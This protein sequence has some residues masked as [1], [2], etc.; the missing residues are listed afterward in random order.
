MFYR[1]G[2]FSPFNRIG[3]TGNVSP[4]TKMNYGMFNPSPTLSREWELTCT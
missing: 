1:N 3:L 2:G 4:F